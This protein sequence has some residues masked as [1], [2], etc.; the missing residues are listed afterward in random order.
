MIG[1]VRSSEGTNN[2]CLVVLEVVKALV[3]YD[4]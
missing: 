3:V 1:G 4:R 2:V